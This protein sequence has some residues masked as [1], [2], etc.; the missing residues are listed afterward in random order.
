LTHHDI[1]KLLTRILRD[2]LGDQSIDL[3]METQR[4]DVKGWDSFNYV[5]FIAAVEIELGMKFKLA[6]VES[7]K[8]VG[9][10]V[11]QT[12]KMLT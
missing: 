1:L 7:F 9:E 11:M 8:N 12:K 10:I 5:N 3:S 6:D 4:E 2:V